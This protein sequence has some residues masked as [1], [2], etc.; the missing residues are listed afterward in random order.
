VRDFARSAFEIIVSFSL[1][2]MGILCALGI[3]FSRF[4]VN[5][6]GT[7]IRL[8]PLNCAGFALFFIGIGAIPLTDN[9]IPEHRGILLAIPALLGWVFGLVGY[10]L[11][12]RRHLEKH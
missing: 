3:W 9:L 2:G 12:R 8:G 11:D 7:Q 6:R 10:G 5:W 4:R 1:V